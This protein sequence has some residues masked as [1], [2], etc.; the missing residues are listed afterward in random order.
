MDMVTQAYTYVLTGT[1]VQSGWVFT[2]DT[3][4]TKSF[5]DSIVNTTCALLFPLALSLLFPVMLY[6]LVL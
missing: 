3:E 5:I 2:R 4:D 6:T 1:S